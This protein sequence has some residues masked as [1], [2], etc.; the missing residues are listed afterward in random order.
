MRFLPSPVLCR[1]W[2]LPPCRS[3]PQLIAAFRS[4]IFYMCLCSAK[5]CMRSCESPGSGFTKED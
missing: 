2:L 5:E 1:Y 3:I 4:T